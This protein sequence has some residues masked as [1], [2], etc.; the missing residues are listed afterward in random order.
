MKLSDK[1]NEINNKKLKLKT[2]GKINIKNMR[3]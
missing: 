2:I 1:W 3:K